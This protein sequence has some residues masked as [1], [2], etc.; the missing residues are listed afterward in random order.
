MYV[1]IEIKYYEADFSAKKIV[2]FNEKWQFQSY[3]NFSAQY[4][5][6]IGDDIYISTDYYVFKTDKNLN[7]IKTSLNNGAANRAIHYNNQDDKI[8][9]PASNQAKI[10]IFDRNLTSLGFIDT[11]TFRTF[12]IHSY[13]GTIYVGTTN[14]TILLIRNKTIISSFNTL[15]NGA[16]ITS[17]LVDNYGFIAVAG[18]GMSS[19]YL[20]HTNGTFMNKTKISGTGTMDIKIDSKGRFII[21]S[22]SS[23]G[24]YY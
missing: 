4:F 6:A 13:N 8:Y 24:I 10:N 14:G 23:I 20:Y 12:A 19:I 16:Q 9:V 22:R 7:I 18:N 3:V 2:I 5:V 17:L 15:F 1:G 11:L 21:S